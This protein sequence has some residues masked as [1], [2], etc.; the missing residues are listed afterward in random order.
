MIIPHSPPG[1]PRRLAALFYDAW[2]LAGIL[3]MATA[4]LLPFKG[5]EAFRP[6]QWAYSLYLLG[7]CFLYY[8]WFWTHGGQTLGMRAWKI[9]LCNNDGGNMTW[10]RS[11]LRFLASILSMGLFGLGY[12]WVLLD[13]KKRSWHDAISHTRLEQIEYPPA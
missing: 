12:V 5:G 11:A 1:L 13:G 9:R 10:G 8:G 7:V 3:F 2:L 4:L 6:N